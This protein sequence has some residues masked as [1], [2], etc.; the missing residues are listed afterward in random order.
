VTAGWKGVA[1]TGGGLLLLLVLAFAAVQLATPLV[2]EDAR[3]LE[4]RGPREVV[5]DWSQDACEPEDIPDLPAR[6]LRDADGQVQLLVAHYVNRRLVGPDFD[7]LRH[8]CA[9][10]MSS[11]EDPDPAAFNGWEWIASPYTRDGR[12]I[13]ALVHNEFQGH[14]DHR[15]CRS[16]KYPR[17]VY[18]ALTLAVSRD[19][20]RTYRQPRA[21]THLVATYPY[22]YVGDSGPIGIFEPSNIV[23]NPKDR[24]YYVV[25]HTVGHGNRPRGTCVLRTRRLGDPRSW[26]AWDGTNFRVRFVN[27]YEQEGARP[28]THVCQ[29]VERADIVEMSHSLTFNTY[30]GRFLLVGMSGAH[31]AARGVMVWGVYYSLSDDLVHWSRQKLLMEAELPWTHKCGDA[32]PIAYPSLLDPASR[33]RSFETTGRRPYLYFT[34]FNFKGCVQSFDRDLVRVR[35]AISK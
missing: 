12:T 25:A 9:V 2:A 30:L 8:D 23:F 28:E 14:R 22:R 11:D 16:G 15:R 7:H 20:G 26:R 33:S 13:F 3:A 6:A 17:C 31:D 4:V 10:M 29:P 24:Y 21:P 32:D 5:F 35:V 18:T 34:R 27:P 19:G 1:Y